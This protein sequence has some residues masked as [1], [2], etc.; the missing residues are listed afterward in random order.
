MLHNWKPEWGELTESKLREKLVE[1]GYR[2][3]RYVYPPGTYFGEH[4]HRIDKK[5]GVYSGTFKLYMHGEEHVLGPGDFIEVP[6][7][8]VH[9]AEVVGEESVVSF[10][11]TRA[12][13]FPGKG[14]P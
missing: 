7:G 13:R 5:D 9:S 11:A 8:T 3:T 12:T 6:A 14:G 1:G 2:V 4:T 10:D